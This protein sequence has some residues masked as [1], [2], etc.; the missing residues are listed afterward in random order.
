MNDNR[1]TE[2]IVLSKI[3]IVRGLK[4]MLDK[5][6]AGLYQVPTKVFNQSVKRNSKRFPSDF[7]FQLTKEEFDFQRS[8]IVTFEKGKG[9]YPKY[10]PY[11]FTEQ[12]VAMLSSILNTDIAI[13][14]NIQIIRVFTRMR[15]MLVTHK[16]ILFKL[17]Q[18]ENKV[19]KHDEN[20][21]LI[22]DYLKQLLNPPQ[23]PRRRI[24]FIQEDEG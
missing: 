1:I 24:G 10:L 18:L 14:V 5:D 8:Q 2:E 19:G 16:D 11:A 4:V 20:I 17:E 9:K 15:E 22:F 3:Y 12:G 13:D 6:L 7:M 23:E 21:R